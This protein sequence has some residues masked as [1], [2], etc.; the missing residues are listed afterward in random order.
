MVYILEAEIEQQ[1]IIVKPTTILNPLQYYDDI[2]HTMST[3]STDNTLRRKLTW[4]HSVSIVAGTMLG[5][6]IFIVTGEAAAIMGPAL[7]IGFLIGIP[8]IVTT[9]LVYAIYMSGPL[10]DEAGGAYLHISRTW[11][12]VFT[13]FILQWFKWFSFVTGVAVLAMGAGGV[14]VT[15]DTIGFLTAQQWAAIWLTVFFTLNI[16]GID[17]SAQAQ[18]L[19]T[20]V[21]ILI[22]L[23]LSIPGLLFIDINNFDPLFVDRLYSDGLIGPFLAGISTLVFSYIGFESLAQTAGETKNPQKTLPRV[24]TYST[25]GVGILYTLIAIVVVGTIGWQT[26]AQASAPLTTAAQTYFPLNTAIIVTFGSLLAFATTLNAMFLAPSRIF[27]AFSKDNVIP[28]IFAHT[29]NR[30]HTPDV[31]LLFTYLIAMFFVFASSF[32]FVFSI[33]LA[34]LLL[35]YTGHS[36]SGMVLPWIRPELYQ[37]SSFRLKPILTT[38]ICLIS[39]ISMGIFAWMQLAIPTLEPAIHMILSGNIINGITSSPVLLTIIWSLI[40]A[41]IFFGYKGYL[42]FKGIDVGKREY[43]GSDK[44]DGVKFEDD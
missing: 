40:G 38:I 1:P 41:G 10:G 23:L 17:I 29:N 44:G 28:S 3:D 2:G 34:T 18:V 19:M 24:F 8:L 13:G 32:D 39:A 36:L 14:M 9:A 5:A 6:G 4:V 26:A 7:I 35:L 21:L 25:L 15:I 30:F 33:A 31:G 12:S 20:S 43:Y 11:N 42:S 27:Y 16:V 37:L 22:L